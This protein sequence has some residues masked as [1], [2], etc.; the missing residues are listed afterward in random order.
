VLQE[1]LDAAA[2]GGA[3]HADVSISFGSDELRLE[4]SD[5]RPEPAIEPGPLMVMRERLGLYGGRVR[6]GTDGE[7][8]AFRVAARLPLRGSA[9]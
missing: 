7:R 6:A 4:V 5:D 9:A 3:A 2:A 8:G 1:A